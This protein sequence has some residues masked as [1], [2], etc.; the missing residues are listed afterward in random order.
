MMHWWHDTPV[1]QRFVI[2]GFAMTLCVFGMYTLVWGSLDSPIAMVNHDL[3]ELNQENQ[4][5]VK[6]I[7]LL[8]EENRKCS[9]YVKNFPRLFRNYL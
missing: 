9:S 1:Y 5:A 3:A 2:C 7:A 6:S 8:K 4:E